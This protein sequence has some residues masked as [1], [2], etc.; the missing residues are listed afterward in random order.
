MRDMRLRTEQPKH[1]QMLV[2]MAN[3]VEVIMAPE[4]IALEHR[5][6]DNVSRLSRGD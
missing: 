6:I 4:E 3:C 5:E 2:E 1:T